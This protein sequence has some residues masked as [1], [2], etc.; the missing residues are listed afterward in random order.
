MKY[1]SVPWNEIFMYNE[2][3]PSCLVWK[4]N[5]YAGRTGRTLVKSEGSFAG[6]KS[7][8]PNGSP[9]SWEVG[10]K[11]KIYKAHRIILAMFNRLPDE[12][13]VVDHIDG[14]PFN[15]QLSNLRAIEKDKN[16][17]NQRK[18][19]KN[20]SG[21]AGVYWQTMNKGKHTY[22]VAEVKYKEHKE[23]K[24]FGAHV[25]EDPFKEACLWRAA[26][27]KEFNERF[28]AGYTDRHGE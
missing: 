21:V 8:N 24:C 6:G 26:K 10:Y 17:R 16:H 19:A 23:V 5:V 15:N 22:A 28:G 14:N 27:L 1:S 20:T 2:D 18:P 7:H 25:Y 9:K 4:H 13:L 3:S 11:G 12:S